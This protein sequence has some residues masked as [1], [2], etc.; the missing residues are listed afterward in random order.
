MNA[1]AKKAIISK[2]T[3]LSSTNWT[4]IS[5]SVGSNE[6]VVITDIICSSNASSSTITVAAYDGS[7][8]TNLL[9]LNSQ[10]DRTESINLVTPIHVAEGQRIQG[11]TTSSSAYLTINYYVI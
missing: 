4:D 7:T 5:N 2:H 6:S 11:Q 10:E 8:R 3:V 9:V 1:A